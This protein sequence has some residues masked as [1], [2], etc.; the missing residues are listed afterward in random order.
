MD[1]ENKKK[2]KQD[3]GHVLNGFYSNNF[4]KP[5]SIP[6][7]SIDYYKAS[8]SLSDSEQDAISFDN[9][10][11]FNADVSIVD[12]LLDLAKQYSE[13]GL[14]N[15]NR[16]NYDIA[17]ECFKEELRIKELLYKKDS[18]YSAAPYCKIGIAYYELRNYNKA[19]E[20][21]NNALVMFKM[22][23]EVFLSQVAVSYNY[24]GCVYDKL[25]NSDKA[26]EYL[27]EALEILKSVDGENHPATQQILQTINR[28][29]QES[30]YSKPK[31]DMKKFYSAEEVNSMSYREWMETIAKELNAAG[32]KGDGYSSVERRFMKNVAPY[33]VGNVSDFFMGAIND[34]NAMNYLKSI[35]LVNNGRCPMCGSPIKGTPSQFTDGMNPNLNFYI[36]NSCRKEGQGISVNHNSNSGCLG[37]FVFVIVGIVLG[38][39]II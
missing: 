1:E 32:F 21:L 13:D 39:L 16:K 33:E 3:T 36:C 35:G 28:V 4:E 23:G 17:L 25:G 18:P 22:G 19:L 30:N 14:R 29:K 34:A 7:D 24:I 31:K 27:N 5:W 20:Y 15:L 2:Y 38:S 9:L 8:R 10:E 6:L 37:F 12:V 11:E 26:L